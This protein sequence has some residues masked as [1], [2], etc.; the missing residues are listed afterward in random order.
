MKLPLYVQPEHKT[1]FAQGIANSLVPQI[2]ELFTT[3]AEYESDTFSAEA[4][5]LTLAEAIKITGSLI[6]YAL[7]ELID[8]KRLDGVRLDEELENIRD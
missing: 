3:V 4:S 5:E 6:G 2:A 8:L 1:E 7:E